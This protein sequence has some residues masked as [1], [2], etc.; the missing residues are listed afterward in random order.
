MISKI[1]LAF[2]LLITLIIWPLYSYSKDFVFYCAPWKEI[3]NKKILQNNFSI[4]IKNSSL[5]ILGGD[6]DT[7]FFDLI[8]SHPSFYLF[9]TPSGV[10]LNIS[11]GSDLKKVAL[12]QTVGKEQLFYSSTCNK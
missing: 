2:V 9:S 8:Y 4:K 10:L 3:G 12:W 1:V 7:K 5:A 11:R 6:L